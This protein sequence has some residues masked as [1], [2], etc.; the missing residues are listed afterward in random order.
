MTPNRFDP[1]RSRAP[2]PALRQMLPLRARWWLFRWR[3]RF[4]RPDL[5]PRSRQRGRRGGLSRG[6]NLAAALLSAG[7]VLLPILDASATAGR[8]SISGE[9]GGCRVLSVTDGD[10]V[11]IWCPGH[12]AMRARIEGMDTPELFSPGCAAEWAAAVRAGWALRMHLWTAGEVGIVRRGTDRYGRALIS[13]FVDGQSLAR[14]MIA[15]GHA[16]PYD[17][18]RRAG[19]CGASPPARPPLPQIGRP[20]G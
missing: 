1:S 7:L 6:V 18:G 17:G 3:Q 4:A 19:W 12:G 13:I 11:V 8:S 16:R 9:P 14:R 15:E 20:S 5:N 10:T 2:R